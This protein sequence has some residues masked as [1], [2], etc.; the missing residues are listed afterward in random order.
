MRDPIAERL[1]TILADAAVRPRAVTV[2][3]PEA[4]VDVDTRA[5]ALRVADLLMRPGTADVTV[6]PTG[7]SL[8]DASHIVT[9]RLL[10]EEDDA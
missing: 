3:G 8:D 1:A 7:D 6:T 5:D 9:I 10:A 4:R 2:T